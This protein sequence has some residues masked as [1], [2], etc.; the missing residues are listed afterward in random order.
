M[1]SN[2]SKTRWPWLVR[3][4]YWHRDIDLGVLGVWRVQAPI[5]FK[6]QGGD[7]EVIN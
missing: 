3:L 5:R 7:H 2:P 1:A 4:C 6:W